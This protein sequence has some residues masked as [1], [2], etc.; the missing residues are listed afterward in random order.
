RSPPSSLLFPYTTLFRSLYPLFLAGARLLV[1]DRMFL[2]QALQTVVSGLG[3]VCL[4]L[5]AEALTARR[6]V[7]LLSAA[8]YAAY[9]LLVWHARSEEHTSE[10][11]SLRH[12]VC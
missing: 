1:G 2:V 3:A 5:L 9:P 7:A 12:L 11:Q 10:L 6:V 4:Y 8:L